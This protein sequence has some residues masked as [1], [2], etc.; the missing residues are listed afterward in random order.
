MELLGCHEVSCPQ[1]ANVAMA[2]ARNTAESTLRAIH[3]VGFILF[4][5]HSAFATMSPHPATPFIMATLLPLSQRASINFGYIVADMVSD[6]LSVDQR[7]CGVCPRTCIG[8]DNIK[9]ACMTINDNRPVVGWIGT[10]RMGAA[11]VTRLAVAGSAL[12]VW[13]R[14]RSKAEPLA[15][16]GCLIADN[17]AQLRGL[18]VVFTMVSTPADLEQVLLGEGGLLADPD[19][20]PTVIVDCSTVSTEASAQLR[21]VCEQRGVEFLAAPVSGN[22]KVVRAG[23]LSIAASGPLETYERVEPLLR[24]IGKAVTYVGEGDAARLVKICHNLM[25]GVVTQS[26]AEITVLAEKGGVSRAAFLEFLNDS[27]MGSV[28]ARYKSL[29]S[30]PSRSP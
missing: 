30:P 7:E 25:L 24:H 1:T 14:T 13:N 10:G 8:A 28:F 18:D 4:P 9:E 23:G 3:N 17:I 11:M 29:L 22:A 16:Y 26:L 6:V 19:I 27:V 5:S 20:A 21:A 15:E 12:T 2:A